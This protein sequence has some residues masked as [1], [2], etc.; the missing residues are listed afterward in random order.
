MSKDTDSIGK[1]EMKRLT[2]AKIVDD[3]TSAGGFVA[4]TRSA[5]AVNYVALKP[6]ED[7]QF[8]IAS[9]YGDRRGAA[10]IWVKDECFTLLKE[11]GV[12]TAVEDRNVKDVSFFKRG[13]D[14]QIEIHNNTDLL[15][16]EI[17]A[18]SVIVKD[19]LLEMEDEKATIRADKLAKATERAEAMA[20]KRK[21]PF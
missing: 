17:V 9:V 11:K 21:T 8:V 15:I 4:V 16:G 19:A 14:W 18:A 20:S 1:Q 6:S 12:I 10:S 2:K 13:M 3:F 5:G 7:S